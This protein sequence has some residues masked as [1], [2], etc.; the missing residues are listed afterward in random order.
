MNEITVISIGIVS[1][2]VLSRLPSMDRAYNDMVNNKNGWLLKPAYLASQQS[3]GTELPDLMGR[4]EGI[5]RKTLS[6]AASLA[7]ANNILAFIA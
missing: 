5:H 4:K 2:C 6:I 7:A 3:D 1:R